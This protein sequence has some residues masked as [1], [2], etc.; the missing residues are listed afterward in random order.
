MGKSE[1]MR[2]RERE[3]GQVS[4]H[5][6]ME[7]ERELWQPE[8]IKRRFSKMAEAWEY[9]DADGEET[10]EEGSKEKEKGS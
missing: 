8:R 3:G 2:E 1:V 5:I 10:R 6:I 4:R 7:R 9:S